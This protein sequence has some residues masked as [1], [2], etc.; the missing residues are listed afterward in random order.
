MQGE[1]PALTITSGSRGLCQ[2]QCFH[3]WKGSA[4]N[5]IC[6]WQRRVNA[7]MLTHTCGCTRTCTHMQTSTDTCTQSHLYTPTCMRHTMLKDRRLT[8]HIP[9][10][11]PPSHWGLSV[12]PCLFVTLTQG[13]CP[14][15][16]LLSPTPRLL[17]AHLLPD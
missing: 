11:W 15:D 12:L 9:E 3:V 1:V 16:P 5:V 10:A 6:L 7:F 17:P 13:M 14:L 8:E 4:P 2:L